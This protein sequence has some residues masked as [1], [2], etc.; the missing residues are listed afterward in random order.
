MGPF[1]TP[2][3]SGRGFKHAQKL[4]FQNE[5]INKMKK[6]CRKALFLPPTPLR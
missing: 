6:M 5:K 2:G 4:H 1:W 3:A